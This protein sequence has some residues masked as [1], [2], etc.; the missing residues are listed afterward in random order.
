[1]AGFWQ[2]CISCALGCAAWI[3]YPPTTNPYE[4]LIFALA[5]GFGGTWLLM[6]V[7]V[8]IRHG[9]ATARSLTMDPG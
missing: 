5:C 1:M 7:W 3:L 4:Q 8:W 9:W 2:F 6:F